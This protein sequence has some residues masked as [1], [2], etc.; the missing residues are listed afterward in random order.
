MSSKLKS[1][2][3]P[4]VAL[5]WTI[6]L[7]IACHSPLTA[8]KRKVKYSD[9]NMQ[10]IIGRLN[11]ELTFDEFSKRFKGAAI[12][13]QD[14]L[15]SF[16]DAVKGIEGE[17][18]FYSDKYITYRVFVDKNDKAIYAKAGQRLGSK[19]DKTAQKGLYNI[20]VYTYDGSSYVST[21]QF[22]DSNDPMV[23]F[24][25]DG[26][27]Q[28]YLVWGDHANQ[29]MVRLSLFS[30]EFDK[31]EVMVNDWYQNSSI[32]QWK[33]KDNGQM[34]PMDYNQLLNIED[35]QR[36]KEKVALAELVKANWKA[37]EN[38]DLF[39]LDLTKKE[40]ICVTGCDQP[41]GNQQIFYGN[42]YYDGPVK[43][44]LPH[45]KTN[46]LSLLKGAGNAYEKIIARA[47]LDFE[48]FT[49]EY[50]R[51]LIF[52]NG[53][54]QGKANFFLTYS[55]SYEDGKATY[56]HE[57][58]TESRLTVLN[59]DG[60]IQHIT[61]PI[62]DGKWTTETEFH[63]FNPGESIVYYKG[64]INDAYEAHGKGTFYDYYIPVS[65]KSKP[66]YKQT[67][68]LNTTVEATWVKG[69]MVKEQFRSLK[70]RDWTYSGVDIRLNYKRGLASGEQIS[71]ISSSKP[72]YRSTGKMTN[73]PCPSGTWTL[74]RLNASTNEYE[75]IPMT[76][77]YVIENGYCMYK[78]TF[79]ENG[80]Q[81]AKINLLKREEYISPEERAVLLA[82]QKKER[83][84]RERLEAIERE[85]RA[86]RAR[87]RK[88]AQLA[89]FKE[90]LREYTDSDVKIASQGWMSKAYKLGGETTGSA[91]IFI[92]NT[93]SSSKSFSGTITF[94]HRTKG[95]E[96]KPI[97]L[98]VGG[99][100]A[101]G[102]GGAKTSFNLGFGSPYQLELDL[103]GNT[104]GVYY[105]IYYFGILR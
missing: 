27:S 94:S 30:N 71:V 69:Q 28:D 16:I 39:D 17:I 55:I 45:G 62:K 18:Y 64:E 79:D 31:I 8:Q 15:K 19:V 7:M 40:G 73:K 51:G 47:P 61:G 22:R 50:T 23:H 89:A 91:G 25:E 77:E 54:A 66:D 36:P 98:R 26:R 72:E 97:T 13:S 65:E 85:K 37:G 11:T 84:E 105:F 9:K 68:R 100:D 4:G 20:P 81:V 83:E 2:L 95:T 52:E 96:E 76:E 80:N 99:A 93:N 38:E 87:Q 33:R 10:W 82:K 104:S 56:V 14:D 12:G 34:Q 103:D 21:Y 67:S 41:N 90:I 74:E 44:G 32:E 53:R 29:L 63:T 43:N 60:Y 3:R 88:Y 78:G 48:S 58:P 49:K 35:L 70:T 57:F 92:I 1:Y 46:Y 24:V 86:E 75:P 5:C 6:L 42:I 59:A 101:S 102:Y